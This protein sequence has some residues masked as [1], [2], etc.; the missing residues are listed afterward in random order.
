MRPLVLDELDDDWVTPSEMTE[1]LGLT[2][3][4]YWYK[5]ALTLERLAN[6]GQAELKA[7]GLKVR[8]FRRC[9]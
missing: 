9:V 6:D 7:P 8:R 1:R 5:V 3:G 2:S 4:V